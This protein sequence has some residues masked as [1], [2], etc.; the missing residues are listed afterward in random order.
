[1]EC[2][3]RT[4]QSKNGSK[5][6]QSTGERFAM[7]VVSK[8]QRLRETE[9]N[10]TEQNRQNE[11]DEDIEGHVE[12]NEKGRMEAGNTEKRGA[13][14]DQDDDCDLS[15]HRDGRDYNSVQFSTVYTLYELTG[16]KA[17]QLSRGKNRREQMYTDTDYTTLE[18][19]ILH[20]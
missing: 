8:N 9:Q 13:G 17:D 15:I 19:T 3:D 16:E 10:R 20:A 11:D 12:R 1:M 5:R 2:H 14:G 6:R 7:T 18:Y 4:S